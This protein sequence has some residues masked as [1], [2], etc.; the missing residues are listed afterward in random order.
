MDFRKIGIA[1]FLCAIA[2]VLVYCNDPQ[3]PKTAEKEPYWLN[4]SD[5]VKYVGIQACA[6][7]HSDKFE[8][9]LHTGMGQSFAPASLEKSAAGFHL[10]HAVYDPYSDFYYRPFWKDSVLYFLEFRLGKGGDTLHSRLERIDY[11]IGSG[12]HTNSHILSRNGFLY[13]APLTFYTQQQRWDLP[14]G[15]ENGN[16]SRFSRLIGDECMSCHNALPDFDRNSVNRFN[17]VPSGID[18]ERCHGPGSLHIQQK[19]AGILVD[20]SKEADRTIVNPRRLPWD[21]Q[22]D[23][24]QRCHLQ[25]NAVLEPGKNFH[26]FRPGMKLSSVMNVFMPRYEGQEDRFIMAS[27][28]QRFQKS[29]CFIQSNKAGEELQFT[30]ISCH[31]PHISVKFTGK[32]VFN[33]ACSRC[34]ETKDCTVESHQMTEA[35]ENCVGCHMPPNTTTDIPHVTVHDHYIRKPV[36]STLSEKEGQFLGLYAV[37][38]PNPSNA[39]RIR[40]YLLQYEKFER[41]KSYLLDSAEAMLLEGGKSGIESWIQLAFLREDYAAVEAM[42]SE[43]SGDDPWTH[44]RIGRSYQFR[45]KMALA[46]VHL[47]KAVSGQSYNLD[48]Q[49]ALCVVWISV[50]KTDMALERLTQ[51]LQWQPEQAMALCNRGYVYLMKGQME[52]AREDL[53][54]AIALDPDYLQAYLN[55]YQLAGKYG[56]PE[57][58]QKEIRNRIQSL[59]PDH[60]V[61][62]KNFP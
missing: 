60:P 16:N 17:S 35:R 29:A 52:K 61:L 8:S 5:S 58:R 50:Q 24:C 38:N 14:P 45:N 36:K 48:F 49:N 44:Y 27:H 25:G 62:K 1:G 42:A 37:N 11:I 20:I 15:F 51:I 26:D 21:L 55:L 53:H 39:S 46:E 47:L 34:H 57:K 30:C 23:V 4:H 59:A 28:A 2:L 33:Q 54:K 18:C 43:Y 41:G 10:E 3:Q 12:Q 19:K 32:K 6:E 31:N 9:F 7:C 22:V 13:Q 40:A 56:W